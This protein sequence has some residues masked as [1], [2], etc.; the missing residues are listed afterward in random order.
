MH[1]TIAFSGGFRY[2]PTTS[3][4][5][6]SNRGSFESLN[7]STRCG[8]IPRADQIRCTVA[9]RHAGPCGHRPATPV[10]LAR[11]RLVQ[12]QTARSP[13]PSPAGIDGL[14]PRPG[15][16]CEKSFSPS[17]ANRSRQAATVVGDDPQPRSRSACSRTRQRPS[18]T[19]ARAA[20]HGA[21]PC[22]NRINLSS[23]DRCSSVTG[24]GGG[25]SAHT[26][27]YH[28]STSYLRD[29]TTRAIA[30]PPGARVRSV[31]APPLME[32]SLPGG[33]PPG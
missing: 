18:T 27:S 7:V 11:R 17:S 2:R 16:T 29:S 28:Q 31:P 12:R 26:S 19:H 14:R 21:A 23:T 22:A 4:S 24:S 5:F 3:T 1:S 20:H 15:R 25:R 32:L 33:T 10:R 9:G 30:I 13:R 8:L 6:S